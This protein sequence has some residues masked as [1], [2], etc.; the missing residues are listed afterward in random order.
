LKRDMDLVRKIL[1]KVEEQVGTVCALNTSIQVEGYE[2]EAIAYHCEILCDAGL[3]S[4]YE[5]L[6]YN[7]NKV[8]MFQVGRLTWE[9]HELLDKIRNETV[10]NKTKSAIVTKGLPFAIDII[11]EIA[12][13]VL[14]TMTVAAI[15]SITGV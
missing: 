5:G 11:K 4:F 12:N 1:F 7:E 6:S 14:S 3:I 8:D 9:G 2:V 15:S 13:S 10:W